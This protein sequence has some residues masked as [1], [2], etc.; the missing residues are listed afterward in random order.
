ML[1]AAHGE[2]IRTVGAAERAH[3]GRPEDQTAHV[4]TV[5]VIGRGRP[6]TA[7]GADTRQGSRL[8]G[9]V[10]RSRR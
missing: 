6:G 7:P 4:E 3:A 2:A 10:A 5:R 9:A 8:T 1:D